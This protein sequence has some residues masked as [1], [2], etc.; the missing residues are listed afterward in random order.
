MNPPGAIGFMKEGEFSVNTF[1][2]LLLCI[3]SM[4]LRHNPDKP[5]KWRLTPVERCVDF[6][7]ALLK[8]AAHAELHLYNKG[9]HGFDMGEGH[10]ESVALWKESFLAWLEDSGFITARSRP[11]RP[12]TIGEA[13]PMSRSP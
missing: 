2:D 9:G 12:R 8:A 13:H 7:Q 11:S 1:T 3:D 4:F 6:Y 5:R 10:G